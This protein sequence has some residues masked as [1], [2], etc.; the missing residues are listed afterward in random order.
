MLLP[1]SL[2]VLTLSSVWT[3]AHTQSSALERGPFFVWS[4]QPYV[5]SDN[6]GS[7]SRSCYEVSKIRST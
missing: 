7:A 2:A 4:D 3:E 6:A 5:A 1:L